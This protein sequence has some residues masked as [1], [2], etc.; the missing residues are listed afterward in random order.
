MG[1]HD[2]H[3]AKHSLRAPGGHKESETVSLGDG[4]PKSMCGLGCYYFVVASPPG[5]PPLPHFSDRPQ[6]VPSTVKTLLGRMVVCF[7]VGC[8]PSC[9]LSVCIPFHIGSPSSGVAL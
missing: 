4:L 2:T 5:S 1:F 9:L 3:D 8:F 6:G 7:L